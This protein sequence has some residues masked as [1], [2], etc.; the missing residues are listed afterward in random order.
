[1]LCWR[2]IIRFLRQPNRVVGAVGQPLLFWLLFGA[3]MNRVFVVSGQGFREYYFPGTVI[4][5]V[6]FTAIFATISLIEDRRE[7]FLQSVLVAPIP[8]WSMVLGKVLGGSL[9]ALGQS[10]LFLCLALT[11]GIRVGWLSGLAVVALLWVLA[12]ALTSLGFL[13]AWRMDSTQG[14]HAVMN[15]VLMPLWLL[16]GAFF[17]VPAWTGGTWTERGLHCL[18]RVN[19]VT[20]GVAGLRGQLYADMPAV[21]LGGLAGEAGTSWMPGL[22]VSWLVCGAFAVLMFAAACGMAARPARGDLL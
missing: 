9:L 12:V 16:S 8:R 6:L 3:G 20:Y 18:M 11:L 2:E 7:G 10:L 14:F 5:S 4:L 21:R 17:P 13:M 15:L 1:M 22:A 19:P